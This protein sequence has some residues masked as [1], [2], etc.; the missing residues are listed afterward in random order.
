MRGALRIALV[1]VSVLGALGFI[2][3]CYFPLL[4]AGGSSHLSALKLVPHPLKFVI[5]DHST[6]LAIARNAE[7]GFSIFTEPYTGT[8]TSIYPSGYYWMVGEIA[9]L[10]GFDVVSAWNVLGMGTAAGLVAMA[11][12]W[13][14]WLAPGTRA[15]LLAP[16]PL[17]TGTLAWWANESWLGLF[18]Q[19]S[20]VLWAPY[21]ILAMGTAEGFAMLVMG[22]CLLAVAG[23]LTSGGR[24][25]LIRAAVAGALLGLVF[26]THAYVAIYS[27]A[28]VMVV[29]LVEDHLRHPSRRRLLSE[30]AFLLL[31]L[32]LLRVVRGH[33]EPTTKIGLFLAGVAVLLLVRRSWVARM[34][35]AALT[36]VLTAAIVA[37]PYL[38]RLL[39]QAGDENSFF[40]QRQAQNDNRDLT[41][42]LPSILWHE[43]PVLVLAVVTAVGLWRSRREIARADPWLAVLIAVAVVTPLLTYN[44]V[45]GVDQEPYRFLPY[46]MLLIAVL[47]FPW[48]WL[49]LSRPRQLRW[50]PEALAALLLLA[51]APTS[52]AYL[53]AVAE[54]G[55]LPDDRNVRVADEWIAE[56]TGSELTLLDGCFNPEFTR[57]HGGPHV[58]RFHSGLAVP[59][60]QP[61]VNLVLNLRAQGKIAT[62]AQLRAAGVRWFA[63]NTNCNG[64]PRA[65]IGQALG[66][67][68]ATFLMPAPE[69]Y[70]NP[71]GTRYE[72]Y[73]VPAP[74]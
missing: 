17:L 39:Q 53:H 27:A 29:F 42:P 30:A 37:A 26:H 21:A 11:G 57:I 28:T 6:Y 51:T 5:F 54:A 59:A 20:V 15:Y 50:A 12:A 1:L 31:L 68:R 36:M 64:I 72:V 22:L 58:L 45:W 14:A 44:H 9:R 16:L 67:P 34:G 4:E 73:A 48:L 56:T 71:P 52:I 60:N 74:R 63:T 62:P 23:V 32:A 65:E 70:G 40:A 10:P 35:V 24:R 3:F 7:S 61:Q 38:L 13:A 2:L 49:A 25:R 46:G 43:L 18:H 66:R 69:L 8:G 41:L 33:V 47:G 55:T 19:S